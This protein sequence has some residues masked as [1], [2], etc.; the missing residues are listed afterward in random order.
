VPWTHEPSQRAGTV[1][2]GGTFEEIASAEAAVA[3]GNMPARPFVLAAQYVADPNRS[4]DNVHPFYTY[5]HVPA[6]YTGDATQAIVAQI[7]PYAPCFRD[8]IRATARL[9]HYRDVAEERELRRRRHRLGCERPPTARV[10]P[11][12]HAQALLHWCGRYRPLLRSHRPAPARTACP[13]TGL[14]GRPCSRSPDPDDEQTQDRTRTTRTM[15]TSYETGPGSNLAR[16]TPREPSTPRHWFRPRHRGGLIRSRIR[17]G[18]LP[19][20]ERC[21]LCRRVGRGARRP[22]GWRSFRGRR[23]TP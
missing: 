22:R 20:S 2:V 3:R 17:R 19:S 15:K 4:V 13:A 9:Q 23:S 10:P 11:P 8:R 12:R 5:A 16:H 21:H 7:E 18:P 6:G 1:H 14:R